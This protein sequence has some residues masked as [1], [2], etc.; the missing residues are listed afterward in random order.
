MGRWGLVRERHFPSNAVD[1]ILGDLLE[2]G[3]VGELLTEPLWKGDLGVVIRDRKGTVAL[4]TLQ[5]KVLAAG[6][7][8]PLLQGGDTQA[9]VRGPVSDVHVQCGPGCLV[10]FLRASVSFAVSVPG[11]P[12]SLI[13]W[14]SQPPRTPWPGPL[15]RMEAEARAQGQGRAP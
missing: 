13:C 11:R 3:L 4:L 9:T 15:A 10:Y 2:M 14:I 7:A 5:G 1:A 8:K 12:H 6:M